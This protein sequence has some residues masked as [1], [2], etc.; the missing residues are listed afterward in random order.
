MDISFGSI[1]LREQK[2]RWGSCSSLGNLNFNWRLAHHPPAVIDYVII[3]ELAHRLHMDHSSA[4]W[5][6]VKKYDPEHLKHQ[7][8]LKRRGLQLS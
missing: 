1:S 7:G 3:H 8:W 4:F 5:S 2:S 6:V